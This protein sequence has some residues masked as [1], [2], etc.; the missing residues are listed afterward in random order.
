MGNPQNIVITFAKFRWHHYPV[1]GAGN[2]AEGELPQPEV[3]AEVHVG[4]E[5]ALP[6]VVLDL[7]DVVHDEPGPD[8]QIP[9]IITTCGFSIV[10]IWWCEATSNKYSENA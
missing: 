9:V 6:V 1:D 5:G 4:E 8:V 10:D 3:A 7:D 2:V